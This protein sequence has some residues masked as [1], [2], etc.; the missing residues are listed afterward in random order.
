MT[1][2]QTTFQTLPRRNTTVTDRVRAVLDFIDAHPDLGEIC[3]MSASPY[4]DPAVSVQIRHGGRRY[5]AMLAWFY[6]LSDNAI[7]TF[8]TPGDYM[9]IEVNGVLDGVRVAAITGQ[10]IDVTDEDRAVI[11]RDEVTV[12]TLRRWQIEGAR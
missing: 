2:Q 4:R 12:H 6:R 7:R 1:E 8:G 11:E 3:G 9:N 5:G 10:P